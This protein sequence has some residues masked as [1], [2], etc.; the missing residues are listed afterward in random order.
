MKAAHAARSIVSPVSVVLRGEPDGGSRPAYGV[1]VAH[2]RV[3]QGS[4]RRPTRGACALEVLG[5]TGQTVEV[6]MGR[7]E[8]RLAG[9]APFAVGVLCRVSAE[10][11]EAEER[12]VPDLLI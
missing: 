10:S 12:R 5:L 1:Q 11:V 9:V 6:E 8:E 2:R 3:K 4:K 7:D